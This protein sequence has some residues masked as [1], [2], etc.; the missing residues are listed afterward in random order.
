MPIYV[1]SSEIPRVVAHISRVY[2]WYTPK[3]SLKLM[4][5]NVQSHNAMQYWYMQNEIGGNDDEGVITKYNRYGKSE[6]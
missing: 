2:R 5:E 1:K 6:N 3:G 4:G